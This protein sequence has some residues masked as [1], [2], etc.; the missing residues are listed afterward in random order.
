MLKLTVGEFEQVYVDI[1]VAWPLLV[2]VRIFVTAGAGCEGISTSHKFCC[3]EYGLFA[4][5]RTKTSRLGLLERTT[6]EWPGRP[7]SSKVVIV[8][9]VDCCF[10]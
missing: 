7:Y 8:G 1:G 4:S 10:E 5:T 3:T 6:S 2:N 9:A